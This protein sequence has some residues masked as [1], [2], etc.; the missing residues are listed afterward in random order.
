[1]QNKNTSKNTRHVTLIINPKI[2]GETI[3]HNIYGWTP[4]T[5]ICPTL[6]SKECTRKTGVSAANIGKLVVITWWTKLCK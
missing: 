6:E 5:Y 2:Q 4:N 3:L 1:M